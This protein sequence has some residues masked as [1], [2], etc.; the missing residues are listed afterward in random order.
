MY[1]IDDKN[2]VLGFTSGVKVITHAKNK[3]SF[4]LAIRNWEWI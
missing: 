2:N 1:N 3:S 4:C